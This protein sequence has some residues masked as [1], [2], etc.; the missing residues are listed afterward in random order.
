MDE[1]QI[2]SQLKHRFH[3]QWR[4]LFIGMLHQFDDPRQCADFM[5]AAGGQIAESAD[6]GA[7]KSLTD[8]Q[9]ALNAYFLDTEWGWVTMDEQDDFLWLTHGGF[10]AQGL[11]VAAPER[12]VIQVLEG[13]YTNLLN[14]LAAT[15]DFEARAVEFPNST[16]LPV[17]IAYGDH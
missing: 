3:P 6:L 1:Y 15:D 16:M 4:D 12:A 9:H 17:T 14:R 7:T 10:P 13:F 11:E 2:R 5:R 8:L